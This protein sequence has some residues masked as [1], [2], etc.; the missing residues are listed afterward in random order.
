VTSDCLASEYHGPTG[1]ASGTRLEPGVLRS[2][3]AGFLRDG[4]L[5]VVGRMGDGM[6]V[7]GR[8]VFAETVEAAMFERGLPERRVAVLLGVRDGTPTAAV[9]LDGPK[10]DWAE[11]AA[12]VIHEA[13]E[14]AEL[15]CVAM[16]RGSLAVTSSGKPRRRVMWQ[17]LIDGDLPG[18]VL[19]PSPRRPAQPLVVTS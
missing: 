12:Q 13:V 2:G 7:R 10:P 17:A 19:P 4:Q 14:G 16:P 18:E 1:S 9:V 5:F 3:D 8:M 11:L 15:V 6:K